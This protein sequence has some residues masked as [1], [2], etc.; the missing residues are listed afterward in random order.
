M[1][2]PS[3]QEK[4][5]GEREVERGVSLGVPLT[6]SLARPHARPVYLGADPEVMV[7]DELW[8]LVVARVEPGVEGAEGHARERQREG[9]EAP[10]A[11]CSGERQR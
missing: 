4:G 11:G 2:L 6:P 7:G 5:C 1:W 9:Q 10:G 8:A 3:P